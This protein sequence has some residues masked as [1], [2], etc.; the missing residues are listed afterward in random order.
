MP[1]W[2]HVLR[3]RIRSLFRRARVEADLHDELEDHLERRIAEAAARGVPETRART[4]A[5]RAL[6]G[7]EPLKETIRD[8]RRVAFIDHLVRDVQYG[9]R[10]LRR[11]PTFTAVALCSLS[12]GTGANIAVFQLLDAVRLRPLPVVRPDELAIIEIP[13]RGWPSG[14]YAGRYP[15]LTYPQWEALRAAQ[16]GFPES[17]RGANARSTSRR[18]ESRA[19]P[20]TACGSAASSS[21]CSASGPRP[22]GCF[23]SAMT[24]EAAG[25]PA[26]S[27]AM[28]SGSVNSTARPRSSAR[29]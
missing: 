15:N 3:L 23:R 20:R 14:N 8:T 22:A 26:S 21:R 13:N 7:L 1:R 28:R 16:Q 11:S 10:M 6:G 27:S 29:R 19:S 9:A 2:A 5:L 24:C 12:L 17:S 18:T 25:L 4:E